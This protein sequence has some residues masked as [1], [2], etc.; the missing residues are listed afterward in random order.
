MA[1]EIV[2]ATPDDAGAIA[3][4]RNAAAEHLTTVHGGGP[5][6]MH[7]STDAVRATLDTPAT[8]VARLEGEVVGTLRLQEDRPRS[9]AIADFTPVTRPLYVVDV[10]VLPN[11]QRQGLGRQLMASAYDVA[12]AWPAGSLRL[13]TFADGAS[14]SA[15]YDRCG[16][17]CVARHLYHDVP[18]AFYERVIPAPV[19]RRAFSPSIR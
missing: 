16:Y 6:S 12:I 9:I 17:R 3:A 14:A 19:R 2:R 11:Y 15:F 5:W 18:L 10:A 13:D 7:I 4:V 1:I 8:M